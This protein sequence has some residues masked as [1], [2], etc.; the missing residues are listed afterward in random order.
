MDEGLSDGE[1]RVKL[2][3]RK[4]ILLIIFLF[5]QFGI[6]YTG[7]KYINL[8]NE[9]ITFLTSEQKRLQQDF[10]EAKNI[11]NKYEDNLNEIKDREAIL[12][13]KYDTMQNKLS[14]LNKDIDESWNLVEARYL[15]RLAENRLIVADD[16]E[17]ALWQLKQARKL[18]NTINGSKYVSLTKLLDN[19]ILALNNVEKIDYVAL[20]K[21]LDALISQAKFWSESIL[22]LKSSQLHS[23]RVADVIKVNNTWYDSIRES[24]GEL[25][26]LIKI[27]SYANE[28]GVVTLSLDERLELAHIVYLYLEQARWSL[29]HKDEAL[30]LDSLQ[31]V[32]LK[33]ERFA[34][35]DNR[36]SAQFISKLDSLIDKKIKLNLPDISDVV[37]ALNNA[38]ENL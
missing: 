33:M 19:K 9:N 1:T 28:Y 3:S 14:L 38:V 27:R 4:T 17:V 16:C 6:V 13:T 30:Y 12:F 35:V 25:K 26:D 7:Y 11:S 29:V 23:S 34:V 10:I 31:S 15:A 5:I 37:S 8:L 20:T 21:D 24:W 22:N 18:I 36:L 2:P 32:K